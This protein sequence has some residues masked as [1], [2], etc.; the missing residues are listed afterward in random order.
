MT[1]ACLPCLLLLLLPAAALADKVRLRSGRVVEGEVREDGDVLVV[2]TGAGIEARIPRDQVLEVERAA[3]PEEELAARRAALAADDLRGHLGLVE[4]CE[5]RGLRSR[6]REL[7]E[8]ILARWPDDPR[9]RRELGFVRHAGR[10]ITR[11]EYMRSLALVPTEDGSSWITPEDADARAA[12][13]EARARAPELRRMVRRAADPAAADAAAVGSRLQAEDDLAAV[14]VLVEALQSET[15][16]TRMFAARELGRRKSPAAAPALARAAV[17]DTRHQAREAA[18]DALSGI[19]VEPG[20]GGVERYF[21]RGLER[22]NAFQ[23]VHAI[24]ALGRFPH[25]RA[26]PAL[27]V[28]LR[29]SASGF[30]RV[31]I[32]IET[33]RAYIEDFELISGGTGQTVAEVADPQ[34][35]T[36]VEGTQLD[37]KVIQ[38]ERRL[39]LQVLERLSGQSLG[40]DPQAWERWW[41]ARRD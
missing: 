19:V 3:T 9:T 40:A 18:L 10:W 31:H 14:P 35:G 13:D 5:A 41:R 12:L 21:L 24:E 34:V 23:R 28:H 29:E 1:R 26:V 39:T 17:E 2:R 27:I 15:L 22:E 16:A 20:Q 6:A 33:Q 37:T 25:A 11:A 8:A 32:A 4:W 38:W 36:L 30:G 7:R